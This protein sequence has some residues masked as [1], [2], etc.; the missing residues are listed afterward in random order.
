MIH[1][2]TG[3]DRDITV[4]QSLPNLDFLKQ[5]RHDDPSFLHARN[6][7]LTSKL[8]PTFYRSS[9]N[10]FTI[11]KTNF[12]FCSLPVHRQAQ[13]GDPIAPFPPSPLYHKPPARNQPLPELNPPKNKHYSL[14]SKKNR[15]PDLDVLGFEPRTFHN[16]IYTISRS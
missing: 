9:T 14:F 10:L 15:L 16:H 4:G 2:F 3:Q 5:G 8:I 12:R 7:E 1:K 11:L 13:P 6:P